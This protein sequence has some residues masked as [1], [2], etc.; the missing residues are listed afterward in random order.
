MTQM[1]RKTTLCKGRIGYYQT[2]RAMYIKHNYGICEYGL[3]RYDWD[4]VQKR[5]IGERSLC[6]LL[7]SKYYSICTIV[8]EPTNCIYVFII[9]GL[10]ILTNQNIFHI[11]G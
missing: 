1:T 5:P 10:S 9:F 2:Q 8:M 11:H 7:H 6:L 3:W 4:D